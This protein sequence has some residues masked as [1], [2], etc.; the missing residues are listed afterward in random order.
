MAIAE[1]EGYRL[2]QM[3]MAARWSAAMKLESY[4]LSPSRASGRRR[5]RPGRP[6]TGGMPS[7]GA[8]V[9]VTSLTLAA[10]VITLSRVPRPSQIRWCL[11]PVF[12]RPTGDGP[13]SG[14]PLPA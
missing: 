5:G 9:W 2:A 3:R 1:T 6:V 14:P 8:R 10:V 12:R 4:P 13:V 11:L 7:T